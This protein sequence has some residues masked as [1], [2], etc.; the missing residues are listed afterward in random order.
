ME[1]TKISLI[2][3]GATETMVWEGS[4]YTGDNYDVNLTLGG[5]DDWV[6]AGLSEGQTIRLYFTTT[7]A[8]GWQIQVFDGHWSAMSE[9]GLDGNDHN[10]FNATNSPDA[11][12]KGYVEFEATPAIFAKLT[13]HQGWGNAIILQGKLVTFTKIAFI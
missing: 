9:L 2:Q 6:N 4:E 10:Q 13:S 11:A 3:Y 7:D 5:E 8:T 1:V 12:S